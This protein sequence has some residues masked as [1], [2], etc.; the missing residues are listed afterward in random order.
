MNMQH[1]V[2]S[3]GYVFVYICVRIC[4]HTHIYRIYRCICV[5]IMIFKRRDKDFGMEWEYQRN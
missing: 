1:L 5:T 2:D 4:I 3:V